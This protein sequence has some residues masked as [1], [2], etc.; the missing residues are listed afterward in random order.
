[1]ISFLPIIVMLILIF[2]IIAAIR[3]LSARIKIWTPKRIYIFLG[4]YIVIG[5]VL[6]IAMPYLPNVKKEVLSEQEVKEKLDEAEFLTQ[7]VQ[8]KRFD[9]IDPAYLKNEWS[10]ELPTDELILTTNREYSSV[11][12]IVTWRDEPA[13]NEIFAS[14]YE[15][16]FIFS[17]IDMTDKVVAPQMELQGNTLAI[18]EK[19]QLPVTYHR[20][21]PT[22]E[23][24]EN[25]YENQNENQLNAVIYS[26][27]L[28][29]Q[30]MLHLN[31]P[32]HI[33]IIDN[34]GMINYLYY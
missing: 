33:N 9:E 22:L 7:L 1:M 30:Q 27:Y 2:I 31:V 24:L 23:I 28:M 15:F 13:S 3:R 32:K 4:M 19:D 11:H 8:E 6:M 29:G 14:Y 12:V 25:H 16:P 34:S 21:Q 26:N 20:I 18:V 17:G 5:V 10:M